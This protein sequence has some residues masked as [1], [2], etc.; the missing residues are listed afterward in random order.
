MLIWK[1]FHPE[2]LVKVTF[3]MGLFVSS[4]KIN[5]LPLSTICGAKKPYKL[6]RH[7]LCTSH[8]YYDDQQYRDQRVQTTGRGHFTDIPPTTLRSNWQSVQRGSVAAG[9]PPRTP[10]PSLYW[11]WPMRPWS[12]VV[13][14]KCVSKSNQGWKSEGKDKLSNAGNVFPRLGYNLHIHI[15]RNNCSQ[16]ALQVQW[17]LSLL[18]FD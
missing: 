9:F 18:P 16:S 11:K 13:P 15:A 3:L 7:T 2:I 1:N 14:T 10:T 5:V 8:Q 4:C 6:K 17:A 12:V